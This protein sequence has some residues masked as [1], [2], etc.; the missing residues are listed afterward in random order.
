MQN[1]PKFLDTNEKS[2][3]VVGYNAV[4]LTLSTAGQWRLAVQLLQ[5]MEDKSVNSRRTSLQDYRRREPDPM[6]STFGFFRRRYTIS[7]SATIAA[8]LPISANES[9]TGDY[10]VHQGNNR[11]KNR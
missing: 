10:N 6:I 5:E 9:L 4:L 1:S 8:N 7:A 2:L 11:N 3:T